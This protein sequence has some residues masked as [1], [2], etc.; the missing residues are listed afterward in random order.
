MAQQVVRHDTHRHGGGRR[1]RGAEVITSLA[2]PGANVTGMSS[3][4]EDILPKMLE[5]FAGVLPRPATVAVL[6]DARSEVHPR[7]WQALQPVARR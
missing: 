1:P 7:M 5:L 4:A 2:R 6:S 3:Q